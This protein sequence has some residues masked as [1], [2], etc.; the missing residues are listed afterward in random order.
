MKRKESFLDKPILV[1]FKCKLCN[2]HFLI[3]S[4][5]GTGACKCEMTGVN[6]SCGLYKGDLMYSSISDPELI[7]YDFEYEEE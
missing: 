3:T 7:F 6:V 1:V 2:H 5:G 4:F